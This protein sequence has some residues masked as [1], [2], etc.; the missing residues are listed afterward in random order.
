[1][2]ILDILYPRKKLIL[3]N[4]YPLLS[5]FEVTTESSHGSYDRHRT[6]QLIAKTSG[7]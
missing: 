6:N 1:M 7:K 2:M 4:S 3:R 5:R